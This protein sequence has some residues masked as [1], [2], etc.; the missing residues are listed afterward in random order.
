M[1]STPLYEALSFCCRDVDNCTCAVLGS[2]GELLQYQRLA[3]ARASTVAGIHG[4]RRP[5]EVT[6]PV[7]ERVAVDVV[8]N[9]ILF[10]GFS[11]RT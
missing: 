4:A 1:T 3:F 11:T 7:V 10:V 5:S 9:V 6:A 8:T 2:H